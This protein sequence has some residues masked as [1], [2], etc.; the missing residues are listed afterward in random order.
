MKRGKPEEIP[1]GRNIILGSV[2]LTGLEM[3]KAGS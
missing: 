1:Q 3:K 2:G